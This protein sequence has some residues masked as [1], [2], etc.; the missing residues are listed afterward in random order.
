MWFY[1]QWVTH[2]LDAG[3][4]LV[5]ALILL[6]L[7]GLLAYSDIHRNPDAYKGST[8]AT[9]ETEAIMEGEK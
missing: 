9:T 2:D 5:L 4:H 6:V 8:N 1:I 7:V 3:G